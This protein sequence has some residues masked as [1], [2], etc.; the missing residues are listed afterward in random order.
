MGV[1]T[2][3]LLR[4]SRCAT[5]APVL[6]FASRCVALLSLLCVALGRFASIARF[7]AASSALDAFN[8]SKHVLALRAFS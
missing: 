8:I 5:P 3:L 1:L 6:C 7:A 2:W 4:V